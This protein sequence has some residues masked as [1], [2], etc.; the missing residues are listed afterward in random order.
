MLYKISKRGDYEFTVVYSYIDGVET[1]NTPV[2]EM[3]TF[4]F[5]VFNEYGFHHD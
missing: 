2:E 5:P 1:V 4:D 3:P